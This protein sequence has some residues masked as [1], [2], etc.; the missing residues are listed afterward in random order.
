M[1]HNEP[2]Q[3][4]AL[5]T[6][7]APHPTSCIIW[8]HGLGADGHDFAGVVPYLNLPAGMGIRFIFPHAPSIPV[9]IN[10]GMI[11]PAWYDIHDASFLR[12]PD[13]SGI[14]RS[15]QAIMEII[16]RETERGTGAERIILAGFSQ[17]GAIALHCGLHYPQRLAGI[18]ALSTYL[19]MAERL[20][21]AGHDAPPILMIHGSADSVVPLTLGERSR[22]Q[23]EEAGYTIDW[24][25]YPMEHNV[26]MEELAEIGDWIRWKLQPIEEQMP[27]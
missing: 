9:T 7:T 1:S 18:I 20:P 23:L 14:E 15:T 11:M 21:R 5:V 22:R 26:C 19:P 16:N 8:L 4:S 3:L 2:G 12:Q 10:Q 24:N 13:I 17:G 25:C 6:E 27:H